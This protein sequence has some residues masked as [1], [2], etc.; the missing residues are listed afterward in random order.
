MLGFKGSL[1]EAVLSIEGDT[2]VASEGRLGVESG[3]G[4]G[5][6]LGLRPNV[7]EGNNG[8]V[9]GWFSR[10]VVAKSLTIGCPERDTQESSLSEMTVWC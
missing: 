5:A 2:G 6:K 3:P 9:G 1:V 8:A 10:E 4:G 7:L